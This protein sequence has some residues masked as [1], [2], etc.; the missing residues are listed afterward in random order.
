MPNILYQDHLLFSYD[1]KEE[2]LTCPYCQLV[3]NFNNNQIRQQ[4]LK[5]VKGDTS[6]VVLTEIKFRCIDCEMKRQDYPFKLQSDFIPN[7]EQSAVML[8]LYQ[9]IV[10][11]S[12]SYYNDYLFLLE[13]EAGTG[14]TSAIMN[15][16][17]YPEFKQ[18]RVCF[19]SPTNKALNVMM[20]KLN[21]QDEDPEIQLDDTEV[22]DDDPAWNFMTVFK[23]TNGNTSINSVGETH[24]NSVG[25]D[26]L[27]LNYDVIIIDEVSMIETKQLELIMTAVKK[28]R[29]NQLLTGCIPIVIFL[30]DRGQLPPVSET[31]S[32]IFENK[33][34]SIK[35]LT[36]TEIMRSKNQLTDLSKQFRKLIPFTI[37]PIVEHD[38]PII[39]LKQV[40]CPQIVVCHNREQWVNQYVELF[41][42][43]LGN[44]QD[45][46]IIL[47]YTNMECNILNT[48][49]RNLIFD[50]PSEPYVNHELLIFKSYHCQKRQ[51]IINSNKA[52]YYVKFFTSEPFIV[53]SVEHHDM[54]IRPF[55]LGS[56]LGSINKMTTDLEPWIKSKVATQKVDYMIE[57]ITQLLQNWEIDTKTTKICAHDPILENNLNKLTR[58]INKLN[59]R[60]K[61]TYLHIDKCS[62]IDRC[63]TNPDEMYVTVIANQ[64]VDQY[65]SNCEQIRSSIK[66]IYK[67]LITQFKNNRINLLLIDYIFQQIWK[68]YYYRTYIW[69]FANVTYGYTITTHRSQGSTYQNTF[70][71]IPNILGC[72]KV[73]EIVK[74]KSLYTAVTRASRSIY[75]LSQTQVLYP[76]V[77]THMVFKCAVCHQSGTASTYPPLNYTIDKVCADKLLASITSMCLYQDKGTD[78]CLILS[79][80]CKNLYRIK[81]SDLSDKHINDA[82]NHIIENHL[83]R[84]EFER[85]QYSNLLEC[86]KITKHI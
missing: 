24:F 57:A 79:D 23:L 78:M 25:T 80:K 49:C 51:K 1:I 46:P 7:A 41:K 73:D 52:T 82:Y 42:T 86:Q 20:E 6:D 74:S 69:P 44:G 38:L 67:T 66:N 17:K 81:S 27:K 18:F 48:E 40:T 85:Y 11:T 34:Q 60:Y 33:T 70:V 30:G 62:K 72:K 13:G 39:H 10:I 45:A 8:E 83:I 2:A 47:V 16:F 14:K 58:M 31:S 37:T 56:I 29:N 32:I 59:H 21:N 75:I 3:Y 43:N 61:V 77:P 5:S 53:K 71:H 55:L 26:D 28:M 50:Y 63:D 84:S 19:A 15:L 64:S 22:L 35:K 54:T 4:F 36:L 68:I 65:Q 76:S 12:Q 9:Q